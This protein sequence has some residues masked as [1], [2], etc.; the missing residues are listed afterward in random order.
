V[1]LSILSSLSHLQAFDV[2]TH[3]RLRCH[4]PKNNASNYASKTNQVNLIG[5][6][7]TYNSRYS[8]VV[9]HPTTNL[10][11]SSLCMAERTGCPVL[12]N[13]WSYV[14]GSG[15]FYT[16]YDECFTMHGNEYRCCFSKKETMA[17]W[18][19]GTYPAPVILSGEPYL[20]EPGSE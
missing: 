7:N 6:Q 17:I 3:F 14:Q 9:T 10:P 15:L 11:I 16:K 4:P 1:L 20:W 12:L 13:L 19:Y 5:E 2:A 18:I 8:L